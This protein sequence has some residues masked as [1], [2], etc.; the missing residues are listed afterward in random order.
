MKMEFDKNYQLL[1]ISLF[2]P[3]YRW[4]LENSEILTEM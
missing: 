3:I 2:N 1:R 4:E